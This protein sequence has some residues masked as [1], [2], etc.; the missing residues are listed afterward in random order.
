MCEIIDTAVGAQ[1]V[2]HFFSLSLFLCNDL[3]RWAASQTTANWTCLI[4]QKVTN[5]YAK[6]SPIGPIVGVSGPPKVNVST[7]QISTSP[8]IL[9]QA[10]FLHE[11]L[12]RTHATRRLRIWQINGFKNRPDRYCSVWCRRAIWGSETRDTFCQRLT[13]KCSTR[14]HSCNQTA[15]PQREF[16]RQMSFFFFWHFLELGGSQSNNPTKASD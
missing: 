10:S 11:V 2:Q 6:R 5:G 1:G 9:F 7:Q 3:F 16:S 14:Q 12:V 4:N 13:C 8:E 15:F